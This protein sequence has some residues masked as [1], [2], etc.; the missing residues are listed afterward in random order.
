MNEEDDIKKQL[1]KNMI[2]NLITFSVIFYLFGTVIYSQFNKSLYRSADSELEKVINHNEQKAFKDPKNMETNNVE[3]NAEMQ[4]MDDRKNGD[5][6]QKRPDDGEDN[7]NDQTQNPR[8]VFIERDENGDIIEDS[9]IHNSANELF[10]NVEF[11]SNICNQ[12]YEVTINGQYHYRGVNYKNE[13]GNYSQVLINVDAERDIA[14]KFKKTLIIAIVICIILILIASYV[15]SKRTLKPII[16]SWKRQTRFV[17]DASH[18]LRT[19]LAIIRSKQE[20]LLEKPNSTIIDNAEDIS[21]T[22]KET[23]RLTKL[24]KELT[25]LARNDSK[26]LKLNKEHFYVDKE[27]KSLINLYGESA[28]ASNKELKSNFNFNEEIFA[29]VNKLKEVVIILLDNSL[30]YTESGDKIELKTY[31]KDNKFVLE[32]IDSGIGISKEDQKHIFERF[33]RAE[34][35]RTRSKGGMGLGLSIAYNIV[36]LHK[37]IIRIDKSFEKGTR[38]IVKL[39]IK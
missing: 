13:K 19:P 32:V 16:E 11:N 31:K 28:K 27:L 17:Q 2:W 7:N 18:E 36:K 34:K 22:L 4:I 37:G 6:F 9:I 29:D 20:A 1:I 24:I 10:S 26:D 38:M 3:N 23:Q 35:S 12:I 15:L 21:T 14:D 8:L 33:Y 5:G 30:K 39:P 25:D